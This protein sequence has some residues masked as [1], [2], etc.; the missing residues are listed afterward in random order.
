MP[1]VE[2]RPALCPRAW[3]S[4]KIPPTLRF[5]RLLVRQTR[6]Y[7]V[8]ELYR[9]SVGSLKGRPPVKQT[10]WSPFSV[11]GRAVIII[12]TFEC[13]CLGL[14]LVGFHD[15]TIFIFCFTWSG[16][17][18]LIAFILWEILSMDST[19]KDFSLTMIHWHHYC[20]RAFFNMMYY[21]K[22]FHGYSKFF[23]ERFSFGV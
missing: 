22:C 9:G 2:T 18:L 8:S 19:R 11:M 3:F 7:V 17:G 23:L 13:V 12:I 20:S 16:Y 1:G 4:K 21:C 5:F 10:I 14:R 6:Y 15:F